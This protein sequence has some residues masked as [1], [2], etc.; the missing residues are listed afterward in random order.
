[1]GRLTYGLCWFLLLVSLTGAA[2]CAQDRLPEE[3]EDG[4]DAAQADAASTGDASEGR[5]ASDTPRDAEQDAPGARDTATSPRDTGRDT[6]APGEDS[7]A[8][9]DTAA[10]DTAEVD[11]APPCTD[12]DGDGA[13]GTGPGCD[14]SS[15]SFDCNDLDPRVAPGAQEMC[16]GADDD[17]DGDVDEGVTNLCGGCSALNPPPG[18]VCGD[19]GQVVC[20]GQEGTTCSEGAG[21]ACGGCSSLDAVPGASC[22]RC[23]RVECAGEDAVRCDDPGE[24]AC[25]G[26]D[27]LAGDPG[28]AC[29][30]C[31]RVIC[32]GANAVACDDPGEN[33]CGG[34]AA[35]DP[36]PG[37]SCGV[38]GQ[39]TCEGLNAVRCDDPGRST[40][41]R[42]GDGDGFGV[43]GD[44]R[45]LCVREGVYRATRG[46]DC[47]DAQG[48]INPDGVERC[49][50]R[51]WDCDNNPTNGFPEVGDVCGEDCGVVVCD[52]ASTTR[53]ELMS[54][55]QRYYADTDMDGYGAPAFRDRCAPSGVYTTLEPDDCNDSRAEMNPGEDEVCDGLDNDCDESVDEGGASLCLGEQVCL[56]GQCDCLGVRCVGGPQ[57]VACCTSGTH[58]CDGLCLPNGIACP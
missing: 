25:G 27:D 52:G 6:A 31:G 11:T 19:C 10:P 49:D 38:C 56:N 21:N 14:R 45:E 42:D 58:C 40:F 30:D 24:N 50:A 23:G 47:D 37:A 12:E 44:T 22:G 13:P 7:A 54:S 18:Q 46:G 48:A 43:D 39:V 3:E 4:R 20:A 2:S 15:W 41:W 16:N 32:V 53:C 36:L 1:M 34:C 35:L 5:D 29:G 9:P 33:V 51:D 28:D 57:Q 26:C 8:P 55:P 17:C